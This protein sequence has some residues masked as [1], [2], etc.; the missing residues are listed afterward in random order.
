[1]PEAGILIP[2]QT[3]AVRRGGLEMDNFI[4]IVTIPVQ[5]VIRQYKLRRR[6]YTGLR[7]GIHLTFPLFVTESSDLVGVLPPT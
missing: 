4:K 1:M 3:H 6:L 5:I 2:V 7:E